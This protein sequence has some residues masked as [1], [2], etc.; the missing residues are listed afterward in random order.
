MAH[1]KPMSVMA[2]EVLG[3]VLLFGNSR[4]AIGEAIHRNGRANSHTQPTIQKPK[5]LPPNTSNA[6]IFRVRPNGKNAVPEFNFGLSR[7]TCVRT[8]PII[9]R[10]R[11][12]V[13]MYGS[14]QFSPSIITCPY[15]LPTGWTLLKGQR[16]QS[17][18][19]GI[20]DKM[21]IMTLDHFGARV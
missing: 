12:T 13:K 1:I 9:V 15:L 20:A 5:M 10:K 21:S 2:I 19:S 17:I 11:P 4:A 18:N 6:P 7:T 8:N 16:F 14:A 3:K